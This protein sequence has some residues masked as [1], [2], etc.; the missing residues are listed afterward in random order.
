MSPVLPRPAVQKLAPYVPGRPIEEVEAEYGIE[1]AVKLASNENPLGPSPMALEAARRTLAEVHRYPDGSGTRLREAIAAR[2]G[3]SGGQ[4]ILGAGASELI[5]LTLRTFVDPGEEV[6][7]PYGIFG[8]FPVATGRAAGTLVK[9]P[10]RA[11]LT[12]DLPAMLSAITPRTK[13]V[14]LANPNNPTGA[15]ARREELETFL[16]ALPPHVLFVLDEAYFEFAAGVVPD[17]PDGIEH[18]RAGRTLLVL[19]TFSKIAGLAGLRIGYGFGPEEV[20]A[21]MH[22]VREPFNANLIAQAAALAALDDEEHRRRVR[23]LV[24]GERGRVFAEL[25]RRKVKVHPSIG[26]F[27]LVEVGR[28]FAPLEPEFARRGVIVRPMAGW[29]Y[30]DGF[31]VSIGTREENDRFL[32]VLDELALLGLLPGA[33]ALAGAGAR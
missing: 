17:Y 29:G 16:A 19:R 2:F 8:M 27:L 3:V 32:A 24:V 13:V 20:L 12:A 1:G 10:T 26:N 23:D 30:P 15:Y 25:L 7:V 5:D 6:V 9:V 31:R 22:K 11:D 33:S 4:V 21:S 18:L 14:A 28:P